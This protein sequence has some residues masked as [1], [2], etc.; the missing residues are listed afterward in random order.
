MC[1]RDRFSGINLK[2][3]VTGSP[4]GQTEIGTEP[5]A[6][7][8]AGMVFGN[9]VNCE[10][11]TLLPAGKVHFIDLSG[12]DTAK[13]YELVLFASDATGGEAKPVSF[14]LWDVSSFENRSAGRVR[15]FNAHS[16]RK[17]WSEAGPGR[18]LGLAVAN[19]ALLVSTDTGAIISFGQADDQ[20]SGWILF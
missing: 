10:G 7:T 17:L 18:A 14:T 11:G 2:L 1:I 4:L 8:E 3:T 13:R 15:A 20:P 9:S 19:G 16:G 5:P 12:L 6:E